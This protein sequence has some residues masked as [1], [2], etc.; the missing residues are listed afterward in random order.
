MKLYLSP[1]AHF[2]YQSLKG[3]NSVTVAHYASGRNDEFIRQA[4]L[5]PHIA[6]LLLVNLAHEP[7]FNTRISDAH[8]FGADTII[9]DYVALGTLT[10][11]DNTLSGGAR[12]ACL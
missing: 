7:V 3:L 4:V 11:G 10:H 2:Q 6:H 12:P 9:V 5:A 8:L 1:K